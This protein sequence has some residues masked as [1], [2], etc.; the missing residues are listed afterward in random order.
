MA[1][2]RIKRIERQIR[3]H[4]IR[5][6]GRWTNDYYDDMAWLALSLE[7]AG[8]LCGVERPKAL[9]KLADQ[10][11]NSWVPEDGGGMENIS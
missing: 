11:L 3:A 6:N 5:N 9:H 8:R 7:R 2:A 4:R 1:R 10:F